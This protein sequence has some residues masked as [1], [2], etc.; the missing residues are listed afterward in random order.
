MSEVKYVRAFYKT[1]VY[2][3][4]LLDRQ[5]EKQRALV[6]VLAVLKHPT[7]GDLHNPKMVDVP[8]FH[9]R[10][11][12]AQFEKTWVPLSSLKAYEG[13]LLDYQFSLK[14]AT[15]ALR[16]SLIED[17]SDWARKSLEKLEECTAE[18]SF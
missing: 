3:A 5:E 12:L 13:E 9:Q 2:I 6:K 11:A 15:E 10:K 18:Y 4:E 16:Q 14:Q 1:G 17:D 7:Q 8:L